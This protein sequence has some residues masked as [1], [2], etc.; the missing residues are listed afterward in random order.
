MEP[1]PVTGHCWCRRSGFLDSLKSQSWAWGA[2][3]FR[4]WSKT[5]PKQNFWVLGT[6]SIEKKIQTGTIFWREITIEMDFQLGRQAM[7]WGGLPLKHRCLT[8]GA[9]SAP[10]ILSSKAWGYIF[11]FLFDFIFLKHYK[12]EIHTPHDSPTLI[13]RSNGFQYIHRYVQS[14]QV[15]FATPERNPITFSCPTPIPEPHPQP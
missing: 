7:H 4:G 15:M 10:P 3:E 5:H 11:S 8:W 2:P 12:D 6:C 14:I 1:P 9:G 13:V